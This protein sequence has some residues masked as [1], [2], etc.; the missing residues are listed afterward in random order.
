MQSFRVTSQ[1]SSS[2]NKKIGGLQGSSNIGT[3][4]ANKRSQS[5]RAYGRK[6]FFFNSSYSSSPSNYT[7]LPANTYKVTWDTTPPVGVSLPT[8]IKSTGTSPSD[9]QL[10]FE[11]I[12]G[13]N[14]SQTNMLWYE[15]SF[16][17]DLAN[18]YAGPARF[19]DETPPIMQFQLGKNSNTYTVRYNITSPWISG[20]LTPL[21]SSSSS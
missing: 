1:C 9:Y 3:S 11:S 12:P 4:S 19:P 16:N 5:R 18:Y 15:S 6:N 20:T 7:Y 10:Q 8:S 21:S 13:D 17:A 14:Y 2:G